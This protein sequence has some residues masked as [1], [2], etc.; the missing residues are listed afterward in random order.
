MFYAKRWH[1][2]GYK[3]GCMKSANLLQQHWDRQEAA[4]P[5]VSPLSFT[6]AG[7]PLIKKNVLNLATEILL[8][9]LNDIYKIIKW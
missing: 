4:G 8:M 5:H 3:Q 6:L 1:E 9:K 7:D 2:C